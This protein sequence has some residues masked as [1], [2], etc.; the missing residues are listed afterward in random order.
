MR[1]VATLTLLA[2]LTCGAEAANAQ[3]T[4]LTLHLRDGSQI[5]LQ[6]WTFSYEYAVWDKGRPPA[7][8]QTLRHEAREVIAGKDSYPLAGAALEFEYGERNSVREV[9]GEMQSV[10]IQQPLKY[11]LVEPDG[12][13]REF[14]PKDPPHRD[15]L[16]ADASGDQL[17][18]ARGM[19]LRGETLTG[20]RRSFCLFSY[21]SLVECSDDPSQQVDRIDFP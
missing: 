4:P 1:S 3:E 13:R 19:D 17:F 12:N 18:Q 8:A 9:D 7:L 2:A 5:P 14:E 11:V 20:T 15:I 16:A 6:S 21:T 10:P